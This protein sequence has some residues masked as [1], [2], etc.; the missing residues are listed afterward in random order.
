MP[1]AELPNPDATLRPGQFV[2]LTLEGAMRPNAIVVPQRAVM[3]GPQGKFV[4]VAGKSP[5]GSKDVALPRPIGV[6]DWMNSTASR[7]GSS[8]RG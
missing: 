8:S 6:G 2:R 5:D 1:R 4:Y 7:C 3:D